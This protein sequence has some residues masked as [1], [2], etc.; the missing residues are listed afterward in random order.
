MTLQ[1]SPG[2]SRRPERSPVRAVIVLLPHTT[3]E[4]LEA[5]LDSVRSAD[6]SSEVLLVHGES[7]SL[8]E[9][10]SALTNGELDVDRRRERRGWATADQLSLL[11]NREKQVLS[12]LTEGYSNGRIAESLAIS[13]N[14]V[15]AHLRN[16]M[17][18][19]N[20]ANRVQAAAAAMRAGLQGN[21][22]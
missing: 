13:Q 21:S 5:L 11:T 1:Q 19:L 20:V 4:N 15:R 14:T 16:V 18:K 7:P 2:R 9:R 6:G 8:R 17:Q 22:G 3:E 12:L 10:L